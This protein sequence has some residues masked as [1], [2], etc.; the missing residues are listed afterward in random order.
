MLE[1]ASGAMTWSTSSCCIILRRERCDEC[2]GSAEGGRHGYVR[3]ADA[4]SFAWMNVSVDSMV[5]LE[6]D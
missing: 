6:Y 1:S 5:D 4:S 2:A 3:D